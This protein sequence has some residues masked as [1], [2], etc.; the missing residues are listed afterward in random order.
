MWVYDSPVNAAASVVVEESTFVARFLLGV[1][2]V[3]ASV[4]NVDA[5]VDLLDG[6][7]WALTISASMKFAAFFVH[8]ESP[9]STR[10]AATSGP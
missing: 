6:S 4:A 9:A 2:D 8:G 10:A 5:F 3:A 1:A 7:R